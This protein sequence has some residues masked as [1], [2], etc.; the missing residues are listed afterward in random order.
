M[1]DR[2]E[3]L[4]ENRTYLLPNILTTGTLMAGFASIC[5]TILGSSIDSLYFH[6]AAFCILC[7]IVCDAVDGRLARLTGTETEFGAEYDSLSDL[8]AFGVAPSLLAVNAFLHSMGFIGWLAG[9]IYLG[10]A[11][12]RLARF[13]CQRHEKNKFFR[14]LPTPAAAAV[15]STF[16]WSMMGLGAPLENFSGLILLG[17]FLLGILMVSSFRYSSGHLKSFA[18]IIILFCLSGLIF[19]AV[20]TTKVVPALLIIAGAY[21][22]SGP[23]MYLVWLIS[24]PDS[25]ERSGNS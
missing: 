8:V 1:G 22:I 5:A 15:V 23:M 25:F 3:W 6:I 19:L 4:I 21:A 14:G 7:G 24:K 12:I 10:S 17:M 16:I 9:F 11:A 2:T 13:N 20:F 18:R